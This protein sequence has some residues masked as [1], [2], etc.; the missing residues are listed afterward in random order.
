MPT[1][2]EHA[3]EYAARELDAGR[4]ASWYVDRQSG[5]L[6]A[7]SVDGGFWPYFTPEDCAR[8]HGAHDGLSED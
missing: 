2:L 5:I 3:C 1:M 7:E 4:I 8:P 6:W